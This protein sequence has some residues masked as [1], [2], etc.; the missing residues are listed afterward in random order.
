MLAEHPLVPR[1]EYLHLDSNLLSPIGIDALEAAGVQ[2]SRNQLFAGTDF[3]L[4][5]DPS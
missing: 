5:L 2:V 4:D 3:E 1:L